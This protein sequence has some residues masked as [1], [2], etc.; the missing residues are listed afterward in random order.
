MLVIVRQT[1][2]LNNLYLKSID[3]H[4]VIRFD[5]AVFITLRSFFRISIEF[6][7]TAKHF[8]YR[9]AEQVFLV[10]GVITHCWSK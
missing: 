8:A 1:K 6:I 5:L 9:H 4:T 10:F 3:I 7:P 2:W